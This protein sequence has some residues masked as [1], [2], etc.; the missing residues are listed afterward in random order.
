MARADEFFDPQERAAQ[1]QAS[2][3][4]DA[5]ALRSGAKTAGDLRRENA[6]FAFANVRVSLRGSRVPK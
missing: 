5:A 6:G 4:E 3:D 2:R 1:K